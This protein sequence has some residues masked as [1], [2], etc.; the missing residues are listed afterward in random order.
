MSQ[1]V[2]VSG[3]ST[4]D[5]QNAM[6]EGLL[7]FVENAQCKTSGYA[8]FDYAIT[9]SMVSLNKNVESEIF[10]NKTIPYDGILLLSYI[11]S[12]ASPTSNPTN[13][14]ITLTTNSGW[15]API[16]LSSD[17]GDE[18]QTYEVRGKVIAYKVKAGAVLS[19]SIRM[20]N[21]SGRVTGGW[22]LIHSSVGG[23]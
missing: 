16:F 12:G 14:G 21:R 10:T 11:G 4:V 2:R 22:W 6:S 7:R 9:H 15:C 13:V 18:A 19:A 3:Y 20:L 17:Y 5:L 23:V 8:P 1:Y